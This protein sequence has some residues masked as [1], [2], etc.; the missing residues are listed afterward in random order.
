M[1]DYKNTLHLPETTFPMK[2]ELAKREPEML[3]RWEEEQLYQKIQDARKNVK[4][5]FILHDGP[6]YA[7]GD[8]HVGHAVNKILKD[9]IVKSKVLA[10]FQAPYVPGWDCHG[11]PIELQVEK[12]FGKVGAKISAAEFREQC[13]KYAASQIDKQREDF[14]R[15]GV[16]G[17]WEH[18]YATMDNSYEADIIRT[19]AK[20]YKNGHIIKGY[21]PIH[22]CLDCGSS[23]AEAEV[24]YQ[25]KVSDS[26][27]V[28]FALPEQK[29]T[30]VLIW[31][32]TPWTLPGNQAVAAGPDIDYVLV[33]SEDA[34]YWVAEA[35]H[36]QIFKDLDHKILKRVKGSEPEGTLLQHPFYD[37]QV[38][39][40]L[41]DH[42]T[43][44]TGTG[45]VHTAPAHGVDDFQACKKYN[46][47]ILNPVASNGC[48]TPD[49]PIFAGIHVTKANPLVIAELEKHHNLFKQ[50]KITHS[51]P[52]C[53]RHKT[54]LILRATPQ[55][56]IAMQAFPSPFAKRDSMDIP[57]PLAFDAGPQD[58]MRGSL[59][60]QA[61]TA[62][63]Q[64]QFTPPEG[65]TRFMSM[66][67]D[68]P[69]WCISRQRYWGTPLPL[70]INKNT[71]ELHPNTEALFE[72]VAKRIETKG[73]EAWFGGSA[74]DYGV[75]SQ[76][77][78]KT[79]DTLDVWLDSGA[80][81]QCVLKNHQQFPSLQ[82]PAD[83]Y[84][85]GSD[86]HRAWFQSSLLTAI[87][88]GEKEAPYH[89]ILTHGF[90]VDGEGRKMSKS[91]GNIITPQEVM[92]QYGADILRLWVA[93]S[94]Y[95]G[96]ISISPTILQQAADLYRKLRNTLR[97]ILANLNDFKVTEL[98]P[99]KQLTELDQL[100]VNKA[101][102]LQDFGQNALTT[103]QISAYIK[104]LHL[105][106]ENDLSNCY[107]DIIKDRQYTS[108]ARTL[109]QSALYHILHILV[110]LFSP[111]LS[112][113]SDEAWRLMQTQNLAS[114]D[115]PE[116]IFAA[117]W[118]D[119]IKAI[120]PM[121]LNEKIFNE[122]KLYRAD[123]S[124]ILD[125]MRKN[126]EIG[127]NLDVEVTLFIEQPESLKAMATE[128]KFFFITSAF[129]VAALKD[130]PTNAETLENL[131]AKALI[132]KSAHKKCDRCWH[133]TPDVSQKD[134]EYGD[135]QICNRCEDNV[136][137]KGEIRKYF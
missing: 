38:P 129:K 6:P 67:V 20:I 95:R 4:E 14:K 91:I 77:Y 28:K 70:F 21:K 64:V 130:A 83:L 69:D 84:L 93:M 35:L 13:R 7:N 76:E 12:K 92:N 88:A 121:H 135:Q 34:R 104:A 25:D 106:C 51:F 127:S 72:E 33:E 55:W 100:M 47:E 1:K 111:V 117:Q 97:F 18:R 73:L 86:Q 36:E 49:T 119:R 5:K 62:A 19:L 43:T 46:I 16:L 75:S 71:G 41:G 81:S 29:N 123:I 10:G 85:E 17:D 98:M 50:G 3:K 108:Q 96:E 90:V 132:Q 82:F 110:R 68:R 78:D 53:W 125:A 107:I 11:L 9:I 37:K 116:T 134:P 58:Q 8:I 136:S 115:D 44:D 27:T 80:S 61:E 40:I 32:T 131:T 120:S 74:E 109:S 94:D 87:A 102:E 65:Q 89:Q 56:F 60:H 99:L 79:T 137:D 22:W 30:Y 39:I 112:F 24:E 114:K 126:K 42:V 118:Y 133:H 52:H 113:T 45:F 122:L 23:L 105:F 54:P 63:K 101:L 57:S 2:A 31:T 26:I 15:L 66:L 48:Y 59:L 124:K 128:L 103:Y